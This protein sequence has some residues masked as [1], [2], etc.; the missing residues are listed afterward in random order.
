MFANLASLPCQKW[1]VNLH[2]PDLILKL[3]L[4]LKE[5]FPLRQ[6]KWYPFHARAKEKTNNL[7]VNF[8]Y[9]NHTE[10]SENTF[11]A[12]RKITSGCNI[13]ICTDY[14]KYIYLL[15]SF[16][17]CQK[18]SWKETNLRALQEMVYYVRKHVL[19][20]SL[21]RVVGPYTL[22]SL[23]TPI[24]QESWQNPFIKG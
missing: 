1:L 21:P 16:E 4:F 14:M 18:E 17:L 9:V 13:K 2:I 20:H 15:F 12:K 22:Q 5:L 24:C 19:Y 3:Y 11:I 23:S 7:N 8:N 10:K 6:V